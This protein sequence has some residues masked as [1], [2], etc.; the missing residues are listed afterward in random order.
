MGE[1]GLFV[2]IKELGVFFQARHF[3]FIALASV[4]SVAVT[5]LLA[6]GKHCAV[7]HTL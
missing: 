7:V 5:P 1:F 2:D 3:L 6:D 4:G